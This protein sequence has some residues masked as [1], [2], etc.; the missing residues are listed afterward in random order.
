M[1]ATITHHDRVRVTA[2][3]AEIQK[4]KNLLATF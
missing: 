3:E 2:Q 4:M 1:R